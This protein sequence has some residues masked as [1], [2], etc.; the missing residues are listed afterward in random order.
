M[1]NVNVIIWAAAAL[2]IFIVSFLTFWVLHKAYSR[3]W[4]KDEPTETEF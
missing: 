2:I 3:K 4:E 1:G